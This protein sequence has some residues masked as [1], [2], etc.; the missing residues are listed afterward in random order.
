M[1]IYNWKPW[2]TLKDSVMDPSYDGKPC[3]RIAACLLGL[4]ARPLW[5][6]ASVAVVRHYVNNSH[7]TTGNAH[8]ATP[9]TPSSLF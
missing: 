7:D 9:K 8:T 2:F 1:M 3:L 4:P 6:P 5:G